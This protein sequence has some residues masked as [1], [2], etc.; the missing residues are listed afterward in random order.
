MPTTRPTTISVL[1]TPWDCDPDE[2]GQSALGLPGVQIIGVQEL[3]EVLP[4]GELCLLG[5]LVQFSLALESLYLPAPHCSQGAM[6][7]PILHVTP[8]M[9]GWYPALHKQEAAE[10]LPLT[11][12]EFPLHS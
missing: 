10:A 11:D 7:F 9:Q 3:R 1:Q 2:G 8:P 6:K 4:I 5:Q 12:L